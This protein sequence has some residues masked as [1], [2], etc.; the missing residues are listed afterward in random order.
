MRRTLSPPL[1]GLTAAV[2]VTL[3]AGCDAG[4]SGTETASATIT[5]APIWPRRSSGKRST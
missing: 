1:G 4:K 2:L 5:D 3:L